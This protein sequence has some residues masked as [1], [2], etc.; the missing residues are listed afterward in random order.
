[1]TTNDI[2]NLPH[3]V[4]SA[5]RRFLKILKSEQ[6]DITLHQ[7]SK[8]AQELKRND[9]F[10]CMKKWPEWP[11]RTEYKL[12]SINLAHQDSLVQF[13]NIEG[14]VEGWRGFAD[15]FKFSNKRIKEIRASATDMP[16]NPAEA[17]LD[18]MESESG[19]FPL[20]DLQELLQEIG[21]KDVANI[22]GKLIS[23]KSGAY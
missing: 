9:V 8:V 13:L 17:L 6:T 7:F 10:N 5:S 3:A 4:Q 23:A 1:M 19:G 15:K 20:S 18:L 22:V 2:E 12:A 14:G 16:P 11:E 21:R